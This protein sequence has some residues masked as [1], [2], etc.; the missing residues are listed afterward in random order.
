[1]EGSFYVENLYE[2]DSLREE[3]DRLY[4]YTDLNHY[5]KTL[6]RGKLNAF[7][8]YKIHNTYEDADS[9][10]R[11][12]LRHHKGNDIHGLPL[13]NEI[14]QLCLNGSDLNWNEFPLIEKWIK[15]KSTEL[16][17][18]KKMMQ[19]K[20]L[21]HRTKSFDENISVS[22]PLLTL[23]K[24]GCRLSE[25][26]DGKLH[27]NE[28]RYNVKWANVLLYL[29]KD[30]QNH[31]GGMFIVDGTTPIM[32]VFGNILFLNFSDDS[33]PLHCVTEVVEDIN[34]FALLFNVEYIK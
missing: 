25:H 9:Y 26:R 14:G 24:K 28:N 32:P 18:T 19:E 7:E 5:N 2:T 12:I 4:E 16:F 17:V 15:E 23:Y 27:H 11:Q 22:P 10:L 1:M 34:R 13:K 8:P 6:Y 29:N 20:I 3:L 31:Y 30:Y 33:D 21:N